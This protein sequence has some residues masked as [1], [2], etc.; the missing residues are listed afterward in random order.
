MSV[1]SVT[2]AFRNDQAGIG[3]IVANFNQSG[4]GTYTITGGC[5]SQAGQWIYRWQ[6][7]ELMIMI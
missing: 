2:M 4:L 6:P 5:H 1:S 7:R 3:P